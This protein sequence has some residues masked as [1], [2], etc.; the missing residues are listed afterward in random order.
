MKPKKK[1][2]TWMRLTMRPEAKKSRPTGTTTAAAAI[3]MPALSV[4]VSS[5]ETAEISIRKGTQHTE[6]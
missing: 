5:T 6:K 1:G 4:S 3:A 2:G